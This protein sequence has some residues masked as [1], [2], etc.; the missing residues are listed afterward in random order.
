ML[1][2]QRQTEPHLGRGLVPGSGTGRVCRERQGWS[3]AESNF[4]TPDLWLPSLAQDQPRGRGLRNCCR[5]H[6]GV[7]DYSTIQGCAGLGL[8][9]LA[10]KSARPGL[11]SPGMP[12]VRWG[13]GQKMRLAGRQARPQRHPLGSLSTSGI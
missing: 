12:A 11:G 10:F 7:C 3:K 5:G 1:Q 6:G 13:V 8:S 2:G 9:V 4:T